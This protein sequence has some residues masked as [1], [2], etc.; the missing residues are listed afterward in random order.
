MAIPE[1]TLIAQ[2]Q[3]GDTSAFAQLYEHTR[4]DLTRIISAKLRRYVAH[5][6]GEITEDIVAETYTRAWAKL[7]TWADEGAPFIAWLVTI[8]HRFLLD[9]MKSA[10]VQRTRTFTAITS[11]GHSVSNGWFDRPGPEHD[12]PEH[13]ILRKDEFDQLIPLLHKL[14]AL[15]RE[16][17]LNRHYYG[18]TVEETAREMGMNPGA[19]K[20][21]CGRAV[22]SLRRLHAAEYPSDH[23]RIT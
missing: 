10:N 2:A 23:V 17:L 15:Q 7:G 14:T 21:L 11:G 6:Y 16:A 20:T 9:Y 1:T 4:D 18:L 22:A 13:R 19:V 8:A 3:N 12:R 5:S